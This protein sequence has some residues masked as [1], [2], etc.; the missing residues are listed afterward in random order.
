MKPRTGKL[1]DEYAYATDCQLA[2]LS[3]LTM[4]RSS[5][6]S[7]ITR[8][9]NICFHMLKVCQEYA[10]EITWEHGIR[11]HYSRVEGILEDAKEDN[12]FEA[13]NRFT[14]KG[15]DRAGDAARWFSAFKRSEAIKVPT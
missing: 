4:R 13:L 6:L 12:L 3:W 9:R 10:S 15:F 8:Q 7:E 11:R 14:L 2:T 1:E 5:P